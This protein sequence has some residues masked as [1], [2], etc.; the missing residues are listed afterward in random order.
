MDLY[1][2]VRRA[3]VVDGQ[4]ERAAARTFGIQRA[5]VHKMLQFSLPPG[6][7]RRAPRAPKLGPYRG[8]IDAILEADRQMPKNQRQTARRIWQ[9]LKEEQGF[10]GGYA[11]VCNY[12]ARQQRHQREVFI[13]LVHPPPAMPKSLLGKPTP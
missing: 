10:T 9:R 8:I 13:P 4:S 7:R 5:T 6:Y 2:K 12:V 1:A 3:V 11:T